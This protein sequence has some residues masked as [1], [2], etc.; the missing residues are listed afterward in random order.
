[1]SGTSHEVRDG[2][3]KL[4]TT[5]FNQP[6]Q[7]DLVQL[8]LDRYPPER[9]LLQELLLCAS[10]F[11]QYDDFS[12]HIHHHRGDLSCL[13][14]PGL[15]HTHTMRWREYGD[16][17]E[18]SVRGDAQVTAFFVMLSRVTDEDLLQ[19]SVFGVCRRCGSTRLLVTTR[20]LRRADEGM[21]G[22]VSH[23][24]SCPCLDRSATM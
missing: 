13:L 3:R 18:R 11:Q 7:P 10:C 24:G 2:V 16:S 15:F 12:N 19:P 8:I 4:L 14:L 1:M 9:E 23:D 17:V 5:L 22:M 21:T 20:Q 6:P